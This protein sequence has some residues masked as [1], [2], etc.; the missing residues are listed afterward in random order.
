M[1]K[2]TELYVLN[3]WA[4][5]HVNCI[6]EKLLKIP[7]VGIINLPIFTEKQAK[8]QK[9][10]EAYSWSCPRVRS[11]VRIC[12]V[13]DSITPRGSSSCHCYEFIEQIFIEDLFSQCLLRL[14]R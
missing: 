12:A 5:W 3:G 8:V 2:A 10:R 7:Q 13:S 9:D 6:S 4:L 1:L 11:E 14:H